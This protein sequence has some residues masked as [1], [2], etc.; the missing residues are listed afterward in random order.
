MTI[1]KRLVHALVLVLTLVIGAAA[2][3]IIV[4]QTAW[5]KNWLRAYIVREAHQYLNGTLSIERLGGN[6]FFG[7]EMEN[8]AVSMDGQEIVAVKDLGLDYNAFQ[9][10]ARG[11]S[12]DNIRLDQPVI[13]LRREGDTWSLSRLVKKQEQ[14]AD[15]RGPEKPISIDAIDITGGSLIVD[16][17]VG[18]SGVEVPKRFDHLDA[19]LSFK[20]EP[21]RYS[22][23]ITQVSFR[24]SEPAIAL[25][26]LSG[27]VSVRDDTVFMDKL[28]LRTA[29]STLA[30]D[31]AVQNYLDKPVFNL[32][33]SSDKMSLPEIARVLPALAGIRL[34][35][36]F[37]VKVAGPADQLG[38]EMNVQSTA[39][40]VWGT[41]TADVQAPGQAVSGHLSVSHLDLAP[42]LKDPK[43]KSDITA[44]THFDLRGESLSNVNSLRGAIELH[45]RR[46][47]AAGYAAESVDVKARIN[48]RRVGL[49]ARATAYGANA[50]ASGQVVLP[51]PAKNAKAPASVEASARQQPIEFDL[52]GV[53]RRVDLRRLP[54]DLKIPPADTNVN[55]AY[56]VAGTPAN[57]KGDLKFEP[58]SVAG[59]Q[60]AGGSTASFSVNG[61]D[62]GYA[63]DA[64]VAN[65][66]L[67]R[68]GKE[69]DVPALAADRYASRINGHVTAKGRGT[70]PETLDVTANG[71]L[72]DTAIMGGRIPQMT[73]DAAIAGDTAHV[74]AN[75]AFADFDPAVIVGKAEMKG[76][77]GGTLDVDATI[78][79]VSKGVTVD[80]VQARVNARLDSSS[81]G[82]LQITRATIDGDYRD[83][84]GEIRALEVVGRDLNVQGSG[85]LALNETGQS[86]FKLHADSPSLEE[87]GK[88][89]NQPL[90]GIGKVDAT[91]TG[92]RR[93]LKAAGNVTGDGFKYGENGALTASSD[94]TATVPNL[95]WAAASVD[96]N[97]HATF[98][99]VAG[100]NI[101]ELDAKTTYRQKQLE[102]DATAKQPERSLTAA[103]ALLLHPEHQE[104]HLRNL[105]LASKG[106]Q[107]QTA[108][109]T[110]ATIN[111]A[112]DS[113]NVDNLKLVNG[114]QAI[115]AEGSFG[116]PADALHVTARNIDV[117]TLDALML[118]EPQLTGRLNADA[119]ITGTKDQPQVKAEFKVDK[120][121]FRQF[122]YD[123]FGGTVNY[124]GQGLDVDARLQQNPTTWIEA[125]G[126]VPVAAF[127]SGTNAGGD[128]RTAVAREDQ[129][130]LHVD[131]SPIDLGLV[132]GFTT[133]LTNVT[134]TLQAK[135]DITGAADDPHP[136]GL[137]TIQNGAFLVKSTG[138]PYTNLDAKIDLQDD[139]VH[140]D[141]LRVLDN[142]KQPLTVTGDLAVHE[143]ELGGVALAIKST[144]FKVIDNEMGNV[145]IN[146][147]MRLAGELTAPRVEGTL[148]LTT[149]VINL[150]P[151]LALVGES[152]YSTEE[153]QYL[154]KPAAAPKPT[155]APSGFDA[156]Q[157]DVR[158][159]VP[160]DLVVKG[161][162]L[163]APGAPIG[164]GALNVTLGGDLWANK[165]PYDRLRLYGV[166]NT[167]RGT[168]DFQGRRFMILRD[169]TVRF[170]GTDDLDP[171]LDIRT[172]RVIQAVTARVNVRG[173]LTQ[174]EIVL[175]SVP[176][177]DQADILSLI[178]F[179]QPLNTLGEGQ[180]IS[181]AARAQA[182]ATG[183][184]AS[185]L[186]REIGSAL[187]L[188]TFEI[189]TA[190]EITGNYAT[191]TIGQQVG[192]NLYVRVEQEI[193]DQS[194][195][196]FILEYELTK[197][198]R[199]RT[200]VREGAATQSNLFQRMQGSGADLLFFFSY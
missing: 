184:L 65:L 129:F 4:S 1:V 102:F 143:R 23:E 54:R 34:Q 40:D 109:N 60:I 188:D 151:I 162:D 42:I 87:V 192:Q 111:Y 177:L 194:T 10:I 32:Q 182:L 86:N 112:R 79:N 165:V 41:I 73:F 90:A 94:F 142:H 186:A 46:L 98:V 133:E 3:A 37:Q 157:M 84:T 174:P 26:A 14:E 22:I 70:T 75:G 21:V 99:T 31:G 130:D 148:G 168:Y 190:P 197:W 61:T 139:K 124:G 172:E 147:D 39:G 137:V 97:T 125:K 9:L 52:R 7:I 167:I 198:L 76:S 71:T 161:N 38:V 53:A 104:I 47:A 173:R 62:I 179:N 2:A 35:P 107:W 68:I 44:D 105:A 80:S 126:Y 12:V 5:F 100:Q 153:T 114:D 36:K 108:P 28:A 121:G 88:L 199:L 72:T 6:L 196:N 116:R 51:D 67:Q 175:T 115:D 43:Q 181:L 83:S 29:E 110:E 166:V 187:G 159:T 25:N 106:V 119:T 156:L 183:A 163:Q 45:S 154:D 138:V 189:S 135:V 127:K 169:G 170:E 191:L 131:S 164:L 81:I 27:G 122:K 123:T 69:L 19:K 59:A 48:G 103:G 17:P 128:H 13:Y 16:G 136:N 140:I 180:Q 8:V 58:S 118:R 33:I 193:G 200:N 85:T 89:V 74:R 141:Q 77:A 155:P 18:T 64:T 117:A 63:A 20:Y 95:E 82:G 145:R 120:G 152:A 78:A 15:R 55:A 178:V 57:L 30:F 171:T 11:L 92:N 160:N 50:T 195:T 101:N 144:D 146:S 158:V 113:V 176:P 66:D 56:H 132:Q 91:I 49:D 185:G 93:E 96:A 150:D 24:G 134:G 149:G